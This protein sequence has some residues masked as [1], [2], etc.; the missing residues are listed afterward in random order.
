MSFSVG[1]VGLPNVGKSTLFKT[2]TKQKVEIASYPFTTIRPNIGIVSVPDKRLEE[3]SRIVNSKKTTPAFIKFIDI[4][5]LVKQ[6]HKGEGLGNQFLAEIRNC[7]AI[8]EVI[9]G[10]NNPKVENILGEINP[11]K[12]VELIK[13]ELL[14]KDL[15]TLEKSILKLEK[16]LKQNKN[17]TKKLHLLKKIKAGICEEKTL[18]ELNLTEKEKAEI[19]EYHFLTIKPIVYLLNIDKKNLS[20]LPKEKIKFPSPKTL[21]IDLK[22]EEELID[23]SEKEASQLRG[24]STSPLELVIIS[25]YNT[26]GLITFFTIAGQKETRAWTIEKGSNSLEAADKIHSDFKEKFIKAEVINWKKLVEL[27]SWKKAKEKGQIR[28]EGKNYLIQDGDVIEF[29]I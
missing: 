26:L 24:G 28:I 6:A 25:C 23:F 8:L 9:R 7:D 27:G 11:Q 1:I 3:I 21:L 29:K 12:E 10:F 4:A 5:G 15:E 2:L 17:L 16:D 20:L 13:T 19:K 22:F 14:M 18:F